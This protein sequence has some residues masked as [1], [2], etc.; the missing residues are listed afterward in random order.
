[1]TIIVACQRLVRVA[2]LGWRW[3]GLDVFFRPCFVSSLIFFMVLFFPL[4]ISLL[5]MLPRIRLF[6]GSPLIAYLMV[7]VLFDAKGG[8]C[9]F[10]CTLVCG[11]G[12]SPGN[13]MCMC[14]TCV[15]HAI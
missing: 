3:H 12:R 1:M 10:E 11:R 9:A 7:T 4:L 8:H 5:V 15:R 2:P 13:T 14:V 6:F